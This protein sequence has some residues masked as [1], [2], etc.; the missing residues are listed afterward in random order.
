MISSWHFN[1]SASRFTLVLDDEVKQS[2]EAYEGLFE[3]KFPERACKEISLPIYDVYGVD[4]DEYEKK[5]VSKEAISAINAPD[6]DRAY[7]PG[8]AQKHYKNSKRSQRK[9]LEYRWGRWSKWYYQNFDSYEIDHIHDDYDD[10]EDAENEVEEV[11]ADPKGER[12]YI[13][14]KLAA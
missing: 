9:K 10:D 12:V 5:F 8:R 6:F 7:D 2:G 4:S 13:I 1:G 14:L 11:V 3:P